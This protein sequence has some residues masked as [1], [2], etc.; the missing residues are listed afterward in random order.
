M[1]LSKNISLQKGMSEN[2]IIHISM[3]KNWVSHIFFLRKRG[4]VVYLAALKKGLFGT[5]IRTMS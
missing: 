2:V 5:Q 3:M 4:L 1:Y